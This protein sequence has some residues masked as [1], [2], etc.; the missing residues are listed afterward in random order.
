M[1]GKGP[2]TSVVARSSRLFGMAAK[3]ASQEVRQR[4]RTKM[5]ASADKLA[6]S[7]LATRIAQARVITE[8]L[9]ELKGAAMKAGQLLSIDAGDLLPPEALDILAKLQGQA[10]PVDFEHLE[11]VLRE[12]LGD[13]GLDRLEGLE[14]EAAAAASIGQVHRARFEG[15]P[16]AVKIQYPGIADS[17][18]ADV[19][20]LE[21]LSD[22]L[23]LLARSKV[24]L[25][26]VFEEMR[27][28]L[29]LEA[30]YE[31]ELDNL[32]RYRALLGDDPRFLVPR[33]FPEVSGRRV[34]TMSWEDGVPLK[35]WIAG[36]PPL[37]AREDFARAILDLYCREFYRWG[38]VQTDPN[39]G[40]YLVR[41]ASN[42][43]VLLD[44]G[45]TLHYPADFRAGYV[46]LLRIVAT[47][48][49]AAIIDSGIDF[50]LLDPRE[51][52]EARN[53]YVDMM[54]CAL[55]PF[56]ANHQPF[57]FRDADYQGRA[58]EIGRRFTRSLVYSPPPRQIIFLHRKLGGIFQLLKK[59]DLTL[60]LTPYWNQMVGPVE[61]PPD[62][63]T[64]VARAGAAPARDEREATSVAR[65]S[66][67]RPS[68]P[69]LASP[70]LASPSGSG[71]LVPPSS[72]S[73][74]A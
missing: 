47:R 45:A 71:P 15:T 33:A 35:D 26:E 27:Q 24:E 3:V 51:P 16:V 67:A 18:D 54:L 5:T 70:S 38:F 44:F 52:E 57:R 13:E 49:R 72:S 6:S 63:P 61:T 1:T 21:K 65:P 8:N 34:L 10:D 28:I 37:A 48:D 64:N 29:H 14:P 2:K 9:S 20:M 42:Q 17:I 46:D 11:G 59:L 55:E 56:E 32:Q 58:R 43:L 22:S 4:V 41:P 31:R 25:A 66:V 36:G 73:A 39:H 23:A 7:E 68:A 53:N 30:D 74:P 19:R 50:E 40:N 60:D 69:P 62:A 12:D